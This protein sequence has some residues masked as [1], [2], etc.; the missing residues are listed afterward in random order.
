MCHPS[1]GIDGLRLL[2]ARPESGFAILTHHR[3]YGYAPYTIDKRTSR[4]V[5][6]TY[7]VSLIVAHW[8]VRSVLLTRSR[9]RLIY[10]K[11]F[12]KFLPEFLPFY[13]LNTMS[14][15]EEKRLLT[16]TPST[17]QGTIQVFW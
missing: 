2:A 14:T 10:N 7:P 3:Y 4:S 1:L 17:A 16:E 8:G 12:H 9:I 13:L 15:F 5:D 11:Q 6:T